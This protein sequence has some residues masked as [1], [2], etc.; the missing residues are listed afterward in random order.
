MSST[1][2]SQYQQPIFLTVCAKFHCQRRDRDSVRTRPP[3][4]RNSSNLKTIG[5]QG[6]PRQPALGCM[7]H[8]QV[9]DGL[10]QH[11]NRAVRCATQPKSGETSAELVEWL[12][13][14]HWHREQTGP[15]QENPGTQTALFHFPGDN[16]TAQHSRASRTR[17]ADV[18]P[19]RPHGSQFRTT[20]HHPSLFRADRSLS[21]LGRMQVMLITSRV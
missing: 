9:A 3:K 12:G 18:Y 7:T 6:H 2:P 4:Q 16:Q 19:V 21:V 13:F 11:Q 17:P 20:T 14:Q 5:L 1:T 15:K 10:N 8:G